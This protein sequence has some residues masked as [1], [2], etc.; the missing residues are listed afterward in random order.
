MSGTTGEPGKVASARLQYINEKVSPFLGEISLALLKE[1]PADPEDFVFRWLQK[2]RGVGQATQSANG[3][4]A[5]RT[6]AFAVPTTTDEVSTALLTALGCLNGD[7]VLGA[8]G[9]AVTAE[10]AVRSSS[11]ACEAL[12]IDT[13]F[14]FRT[15][16]N[17]HVDAGRIAKCFSSP[18]DVA[19]AFKV[20]S[21]AVETFVMSAA[22][23]TPDNHFHNWSHAFD[24]FQFCFLSL[25]SGG[26]G[27]LFTL[28]EILSL[29]CATFASSLGHP[30]HTNAYLVNTSD[31]LS[32]HYNDKSPI[33]N[34]CASSFFEL[35][36]KPGMN[37]LSKMASAEFKVFRFNVIHAVLAMD[38]NQHYSLVDMLAAFTSTRSGVTPSFIA[39]KEDRLL[40]VK[41]VCHMSALAHTCRPWDVH[42]H[43]V[44]CMEEEFFAQG[45]QERRAGL[46]VSPLSDRDKD[47]FASVQGFYLKN[48]VKPL[49]EPYCQFLSGE[50]G[51]VLKKHLA[52]NEARW[53]HLLE[54]N[55]TKSAARLVA[56]E[57]GLPE[58]EEDHDC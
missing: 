14:D 17:I 27:V 23:K 46:P 29:L 7:V 40:L 33:Q 18:Y 39:D 3:G 4:G 57:S 2:R 49:L 42:K 51:P 24:V 13:G 48:L 36:G 19:S 32:M 58:E 38:M 54:Q 16:G 5:A 55:G 6:Q 1:Q 41:A 53:A 47:S 37:F 43:F 44:T 45:D 26:I 52:A 20:Q 10:P 11:S 22:T 21:E 56:I 28:V 35:L 15:R 30:G 34:F 9:E 31:E 25:T 12:M 8:G 50:V